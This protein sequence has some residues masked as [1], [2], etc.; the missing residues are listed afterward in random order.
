M[1]R[2]AEHLH[3]ILRH[4]VI[5]SRRAFEIEAGQSQPFA[6]SNRCKNR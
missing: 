5:D 1:P 3:S 4:A 6:Q 2:N